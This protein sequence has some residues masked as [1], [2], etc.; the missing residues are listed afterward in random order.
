VAAGVLTPG[1]LAVRQAGIHGQHFSCTQVFLAQ[2]PTKR[3][4]SWRPPEP[5]IKTSYLAKYATMATN[6]DTRAVF[7]W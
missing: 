4:K 2:E 6:A 3:K 7:R 5:R 1:E